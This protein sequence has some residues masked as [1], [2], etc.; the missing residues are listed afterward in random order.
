MGKDKRRD[1]VI[2]PYQ[3]P[4]S[5]NQKQEPLP[6]GKNS[7]VSV[8]ALGCLMFPASFVA[9]FVVCNATGQGRIGVQPSIGDVG[10]APSF[11]AAA[12]VAFAFI[13]AMVSAKQ[14]R[15]GDR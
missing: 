5:S 15:R 1:E 8:L 3:S 10:L 6:D 14:P 11:A 12:L 2:N 7:T 9:F 4:R 13:W